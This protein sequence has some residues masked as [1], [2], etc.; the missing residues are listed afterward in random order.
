MYVIFGYLANDDAVLLQYKLYYRRTY[1][2]R[3][4][5]NAN[6]NILKKKNQKFLLFVIY[7]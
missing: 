4:R 3:V 1:M 5:S 6:S 2:F 7:I